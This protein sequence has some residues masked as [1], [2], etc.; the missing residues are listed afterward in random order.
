MNRAK[1]VAGVLFVASV[2]TGTILDVRA[3][4]RRV[5]PGSILAADLHVHPFPG[6]GGLTT[7]ELQ[8]EA[9]RR[10]LDVIAVTGHNNRFAVALGRAFP[11]DPN[12]PILLAGQELTTPSFHIIAIGIERLV[13]WRLPAHE[14]IADIHAQGGVAIAAHPGRASWRVD[15]EEALRALDGAEVAHPS[16][17]SFSRARREFE[18]FFRHVQSLNPAVAPIGS[19]DFHMTAPLGLCR[20]YLLV[21]ER[22]ATGALDAIRQGRTVARD[23]RGLLY[24]SAPDVARVESW[25][26]TSDVP[27]PETPEAVAA[28]GALA[29]LAV[30]CLPSGPGARRR[31]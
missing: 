1:A 20:T 16:A 18:A 10:G 5:E 8:R 23:S 25:L 30:L 22:S 7:W 12:G 15:D 26:L 21:N 4:T 17:A 13:D 9:A 27:A 31:E 3:R 14:A 11:H 6:D 19:S 29:G 28:V 24:G 2:L